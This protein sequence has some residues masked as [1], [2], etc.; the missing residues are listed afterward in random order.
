MR[1]ICQSRALFQE[2]DAIHRKLCS[3]SSSS[4][5]S[6]SSPAMTFGASKFHAGV[7]N[8][9]SSSHASGRVS[10]MVG[11]SGSTTSTS[12]SD[13]GSGSGGREL[14]RSQC[15]SLRRFVEHAAESLL[16]AH[17]RLGLER[18]PGACGWGGWMR[19]GMWTKGE[20]G[21]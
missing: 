15:A 7:A 19:V 16:M 20:C 14:L 1:I 5:S 2:M 13:S 17:T 18:P 4:S 10:G 11:A 12:G 8:T 9:G 6:S 21:W 3:F